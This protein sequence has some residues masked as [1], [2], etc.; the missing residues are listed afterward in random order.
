MEVSEK[1]TF[2]SEA[3]AASMPP[4]RTG[5]QALRRVDLLAVAIAVAGLVLACVAGLVVAAVELARLI[6][7][8]WSD[9]FGRG[10][11]IMFGLA[12]GWI[13]IRRNKM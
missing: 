3:E 10:G 2:A 4:E 8:V 5:N 12:A 13:V 11:I 1:N 7:A 9:P 6:P